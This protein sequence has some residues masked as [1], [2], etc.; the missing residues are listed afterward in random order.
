MTADR[1]LART[2]TAARAILRD[3]DGAVTV[4]WVVMSA[5]AVGL[6][7]SSVLAVRG[8]AGALGS[9]I[10]ASLTAASVVALAARDLVVN[11]G[12]D[13]AG[14]SF[15]AGHY[16]NFDNHLEGWTVLSPAG[17]RVD[18]GPGPYFGWTG[19]H[20]GPDEYFVDMVGRPGD[21]LD[22]AQ[23]FDVPQGQQATVSFDIG[24]HVP[25][26]GMNVYWGNQLIAAFDGSN[27]P[28]QRFE[29]VSYTVEGGAGDGSNSLRFQATDGSGWT[30]TLLANV[31][32]R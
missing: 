26:S 13:P 5:A 9:D 30:G 15:S 11:G 24:A 27:T 18:I 28:Y 10:D 17:Q 8:G 7:L 22:F 20:L 19:N 6:G 2:L 4:D 21:R 29:T 3:S 16:W 25:Q 12:F 1:I 31:A 14:F 23:S 32:V